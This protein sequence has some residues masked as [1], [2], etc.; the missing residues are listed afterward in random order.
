VKIL[1][2]GRNGQVG[3]ELERALPALGEVIATDRATLDLADPDAIRRVVRDAKPDVIVNAAAYTAVDRAETEEAIAVAV[4]AEG[5]A[6]L[7]AEA[8]KLGALLIHFSTDYVF[9]GE[10][11]SPYAESDATAP[12]NAYGRSKLAGEKAVQASGCRHLIFRTSWVYAAAG[13]NFLITMLRLA[14]SGKP[15]QVVDDQYGAPTSN[16]MIAAAVTEILRNSNRDQAVE[17]IF[18]MSARGKTTWHRFAQAIFREKRVDANLT[19]IPSSAYT[20]AARRPRY[21]VLDNSA[22]E[23]RFGLC[24]PSWETG[25]Q[26]II[27]TMAIA[28]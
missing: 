9:D 14:R 4:N 28:K 17:G 10:K 18:H 16:L 3:W 12:L 21:S 23:R 11:R 26:E 27:A 22:L 15:L 19:A 7:A 20:T 2:T 6:V 13:N 24:L 8:A 1:L 25:L 5:P